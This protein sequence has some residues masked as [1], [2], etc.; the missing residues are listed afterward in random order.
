MPLKWGDKPDVAI[1]CP[2]CNTTFNVRPSELRHDKSVKCPPLLVAFRA[3]STPHQVTPEPKPAA[4]WLLSCGHSLPQL[5]TGPPRRSAAP[6][7]HVPRLRTVTECRR[8]TSASVVL[9]VA[10]RDP[11]RQ[12][13]HLHLAR[14]VRERKQ[15]PV[16]RANWGDPVV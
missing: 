9:D 15:P 14:V 7:A 8:S 3:R 4:M 1:T 6:T 12:A 13:A 2:H 11:V 10:D 5:A 16:L